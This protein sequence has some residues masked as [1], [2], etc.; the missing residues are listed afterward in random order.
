MAQW[1][2]CL[3]RKY[4][5]LSLDSQNP[6]KSEIDGVPTRT[7]STQESESGDPQGKLAI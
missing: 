7:P 5:N 6:H 3:S 2:V 1:I 4:E